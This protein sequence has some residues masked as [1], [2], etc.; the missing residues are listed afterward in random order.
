[1]FSQ[2]RFAAATAA[3]RVA[4]GAGSDF[5]GPHAVVVASSTISRPKTLR[6]ALRESAAMNLRDGDGIHVDSFQ[7]P[8]VDAPSGEF[9]CAS[10]DLVRRAVPRP[11]E[12]K[13]P[14]DGA[15]VVLGGTRMPLIERELFDRREEPKP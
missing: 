5:I 4:T 2:A 10:R 8:H 3:S 11:P 12:R 9:R 13:D 1:M 6:Q 14:A 7:A 15:E